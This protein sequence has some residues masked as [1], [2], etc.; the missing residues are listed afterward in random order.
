MSMLARAPVNGQAAGNA[1]VLP[2]FRF[3]V[4]LPKVITHDLKLTTAVPELDIF[5]GDI[6]P[7]AGKLGPVL[8]Q[9]PPSLAFDGARDA[10]FCHALRKRCQG[11]IVIEP[12]H[13]SWASP[14][15]SAILKQ[16]AIERVYADPQ[17]PALRDAVDTAGFIYLRLHGAPKIYYS[18]YSSAELATAARLLRTAAAGSWCIFDNTASGAALRNALALRACPDLA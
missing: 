1:G 12:R 6:A 2:H 13:V 3:A 9:L 11:R 14:D 15:A 18:T 7:L 8:V 16:N 5:F 17:D 10:A 4:K